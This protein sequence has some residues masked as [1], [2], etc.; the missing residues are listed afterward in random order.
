MDWIEGFLEYTE[1]RPSP[2]IF[3]LWSAISVVAAAL[4]RR[5]WL[6]T[7]QSRV[8]PNLFVLLVAPPGLGKSQAVA[9][10]E[11]LVAAAK[12]SHLAAHSITKAALVDALDRALTAKP[13]NGGKNL[14]EYHSL[15][16]ISGEFGVLIPAHDLGFLSVLNDIYDCPDRRREERRHMENPID[17]SF[18]QLNI[19]AGSQPSYLASILP[20]EAWSMGFTSRL[21]MIYAGTTPKVKL[22]GEKFKT[23]D[24][25]KKK[26]VT[27]LA[28]YHDLYGE[29]SVEPAAIAAIEAWAETGLAPIPSH[30]KLAHYLPRRI[31]QIL[32]LCM[33]ACAS[34]SRSLHITLGDFQRAQTW[35]LDAEATM[36]NIFREMSQKSDAAVIQDLHFF[37]WGEYNK[38]KKHLHESLLI[39]YLS[40]KV[41]SEKISKILEIAER[42]NYIQRF[43]QNLYI[44]LPSNNQ[45]VE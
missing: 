41:S 33:V 3:R 37:M 11:E 18:P 1:G 28:A 31:L 34:R 23:R 45:G 16:V 39:H 6:D 17:I 43:G 32:K 13:M 36:P 42:A 19:L 29:F 27:E 22:F 44:P 20:E 2:Y 4:E 38:T 40:S 25:L 24:A 7:A 30:T 15:Y 5:C 35:L 9:P 14:V 10:A 21:L 26:L 12:K 8:Y